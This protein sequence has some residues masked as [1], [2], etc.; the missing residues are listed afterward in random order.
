M[1]TKGKDLGGDGSNNSNNEIQSLLEHLTLQNDA[2]SSSNRL[3]MKYN[4]NLK[5]QTNNIINLL[6]VLICITSKDGEYYSFK[7][8][9]HINKLVNS[10]RLSWFESLYNFLNI[11]EN[12]YETVLIS[13]IVLL[14]KEERDKHTNIEKN[15]EENRNKYE[16]VNEGAGN[17]HECL[18]ESKFELNISLVDFVK[19]LDIDETV[20]LFYSNILNSLNLIHNSTSMKK[21]IYDLLILL[22]K[23]GASYTD[24]LNYSQEFKGSSYNIHF[25]RFKNK[26]TDSEE[27][28]IISNFNET[29]SSLMNE[30][31]E[32]INLSKYFCFERCVV[33]NRCN[34]RF[35]VLSQ[36]NNLCWSDRISDMN[37]QFLQDYTFLFNFNNP[38]RKLIFNI[39]SSFN[40]FIANFITGSIDQLNVDKSSFCFN[41]NTI[42]CKDKHNT[43]DDD[44]ASSCLPSNNGNNKSLTVNETFEKILLFLNEN[45]DILNSILISP[46]KT[47]VMSKLG[48]ENS[49]YTNNSSSFNNHTS[50]ISSINSF[51]TCVSQGVNID[52][53]NISSFSEANYNKH[54]INDFPVSISI[55]ENDNDDTCN[56]NRQRSNSE[57][58]TLSEFLRDDFEIHTPLNNYEHQRDNFNAYVDTRNKEDTSS[59]SD[60]QNVRV[61]FFYDDSLHTCEWILL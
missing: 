55:S 24:G 53:I 21:L 14:S 34:L 51:T 13:P 59:K 11:T 31:L 52:K 33:F 37:T 26:N 12:T 60:E 1:I 41:K 7:E 57:I 15:Q 19:E 6:K 16:Y 40:Q 38:R 29:N 3:L 17:K 30:G 54:E 35:L 43:N 28:I 56:R 58:T 2:Y 10:C 4:N 47:N 49:N 61:D 5:S 9:E 23:G 39:I 50:I 42:N 32:F 46:N 48:N 8:N 36:N 45:N 27:G 44:D 22:C 25:V 20:K 18:G